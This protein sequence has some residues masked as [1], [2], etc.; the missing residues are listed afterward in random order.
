M[1]EVIYLKIKGRIRNIFKFTV[2]NE[3]RWKTITQGLQIKSP[4][5][6]QRKMDEMLEKWRL[7]V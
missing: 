1:R 4:I 5:F 6:E 3:S 2:S 7:L